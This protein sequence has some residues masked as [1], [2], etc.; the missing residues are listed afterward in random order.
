MSDPVTAQLGSFSSLL[1]SHGNFFKHRDSFYLKTRLQQLFFT[2]Q[3]ECKLICP[4]HPASHDLAQTCLPSFMS[5]NW[6]MHAIPSNQT[7]CLQLSKQSMLLTC[8]SHSLES[9]LHPF[10]TELIPTQTSNTG[11]HT[12][13]AHQVYL[14]VSLSHHAP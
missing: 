14:L 7:R 11:P 6:A 4:A 2:L 12:Y 10:T 8:C 1:I 13:C 5:C 9:S 3:T